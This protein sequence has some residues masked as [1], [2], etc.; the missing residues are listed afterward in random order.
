MYNI[1]FIVM[2]K[3]FRQLI[4]QIKNYISL[5]KNQVIKRYN[6]VFGF[7]KITITQKRK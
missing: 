2:N 7:S 5:E 4:E 1:L 6:L 3:L